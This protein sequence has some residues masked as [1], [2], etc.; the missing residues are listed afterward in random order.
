MQVRG[1]P[2]TVRNGT[3]VMASPPPSSLSMSFPPSKFAQALQKVDMAACRSEV[4]E[5]PV[6]RLPQ[7]LVSHYH[8]PAVYLVQQQS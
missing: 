5:K 3:A 7:S 6:N 8:S 1:S 2:K 4:C